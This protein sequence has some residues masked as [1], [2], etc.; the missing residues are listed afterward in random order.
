MESGV[1]YRQGRGGPGPSVF[2]T[3]G[4]EG[5]MT[6]LDESLMTEFIGMVMI[7]WVKTM[8]DGSLMTKSISIVMIRWVRRMHDIPRR[9]PDDRVDWHRNNP[10]G[11]EDAWW[12]P[13]D[14]VDRHGH[15]LM[16][17]E[18]AWQMPNN[19]VDRHGRVCHMMSRKVPDNAFGD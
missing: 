16:G 13:N 14:E 12:I 15:N 11:Q 17:Q 19:R 18:D 6:S 3:N 1:I 8:H 2:Q 7:Q 9:I 4:S 10:M 5:C